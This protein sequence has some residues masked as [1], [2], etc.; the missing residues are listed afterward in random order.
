MLTSAHKPAISLARTNM[1][2]SMQTSMFDLHS[3]LRDK[4]VD[5]NAM[6]RS[7]E[8]K[9]LSLVSNAKSWDPFRGGKHARNLGAELLIPKDIMKSYIIV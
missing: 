1:A 8:S 2:R 9:A 7:H 4:S 5:I 6:K 3:L